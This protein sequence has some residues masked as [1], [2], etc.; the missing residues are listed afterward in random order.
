MAKLVNEA[1]ASTCAQSCADGVRGRAH[2]RRK[3]PHKNIKPIGVGAGGETP[4][5]LGLLTTIGECGAVTQQ[6][7][8]GGGR[9]GGSGEV[10]KYVDVLF[11]FVATK[12]DE[13]QEIA[14]HPDSLTHPA[15]R[16]HRIDC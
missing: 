9:R 13:E 1:R 16:H 7:T 8:A 2:L 11:R 5:S 14:P 4:S 3:T 6:H 12:K 15:P 10:S